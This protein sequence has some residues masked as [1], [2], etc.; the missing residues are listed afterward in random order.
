[1]GAD[2]RT[3]RVNLR[4]TGC[5][6]WVWLTTSALSAGEGR[7]GAGGGASS[8]AGS[9]EGSTLKSPG[10]VTV[11]GSWPPISSTGKGSKETQQVKRTLLLGRPER[12]GAEPG[13]EPGA[14]AS[15]WHEKEQT[16]NKQ[17]NRT[18]RPRARPSLKSFSRFPSSSPTCER[19]QQNLQRL[20]A[21]P[22]RQGLGSRD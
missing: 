2:G 5:W 21:P 15:T 16:P 17:T 8:K 12:K 14:H 9:K 6:N 1:M 11:A 18:R 19:Q 7:G 4:S 20:V 13:A 3:D 22:W 10:S